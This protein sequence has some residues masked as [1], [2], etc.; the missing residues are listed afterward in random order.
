[1]TSATA[2]RLT[3]APPRAPCSSG[4]PRSSPSIRLTSAASTGSRRRLV[5]FSTSTQIP[6]RPTASTG[7]NAGST[8]TPASSSAPPVRI[9]VTSTPSTLASGTACPAARTFS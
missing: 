7:P 3:G 2:S 9:G 5:S 8:V 4:S 6:P 1:M